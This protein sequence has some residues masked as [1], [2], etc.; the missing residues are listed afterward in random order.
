MNLELK[1]LL[2]ESLNKSEVKDEV[3]KVMNSSDLKAKIEKMVADKLKNNKQLESKM[4]E[5]TKEVVANI[6]KNLWQKKSFWN[7]G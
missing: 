5:I 4:E 3:V 1:T 7:N 2:R 6:F